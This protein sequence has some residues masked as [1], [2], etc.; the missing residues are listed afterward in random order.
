MKFIEEHRDL[1][2]VNTENTAEPYCLAHCISSE[3]GMFGGI[4]VEFNKRWDMKNVLLKKY[5]DQQINFRIHGAAVFPEEVIHNGV[6]TVV[7]NLVTKLTVA[8]RPTYKS[9][10]KS[11]ILMKEH[12]VVSGFTKLAI[13]KIGCGI[14]GLDWS[15]V[16]DM[17]IQVF[18]GT[19]IEILVCIK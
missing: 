7:Y 12:M 6:K 10:E 8:H 17:I 4:V 16:K 19:D 18:E 14:D 3:F 13:P 5:G 11:L 2:E 9:L 1:F 15:I